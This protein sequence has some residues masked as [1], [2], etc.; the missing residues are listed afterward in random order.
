MS[1][2]AKAS[3]NSGQGKQWRFIW[4]LN[5]PP[6][7]KMLSWKACRGI[8][9]SS[10]MLGSRI[11]DYDMKCRICGALEDSNVHSVL[12]CTLAGYIWDGVKTNWKWREVAFRSLED[13]VVMIGETLTTEEVEKCLSIDSMEHMENQNTH[14]NKCLNGRGNS[15]GPIRRRGREPKCSRGL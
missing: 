10:G 15:L 3:S 6:R 2:D 5:V 4:K 8:L 12:E 9:S 11:P 1:I 13:W 7:I 14:L